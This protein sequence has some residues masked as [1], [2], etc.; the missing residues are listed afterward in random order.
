MLEGCKGSLQYRYGRYKELKQV[1]FLLFFFSLAPL[2]PQGAPEVFSFFFFFPPPWSLLGDQ[3]VFFLFSTSMRS[4]SRFF[5]YSLYNNFHY[6]MYVCLCVCGCGCV[7]YIR[8]YMCKERGYLYV[9]I[10]IHTY[11]Y[12]T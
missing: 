1:F 12:T 5:F 6:E 10:Y 7:S 11:I 8:G 9:Y 2:W 3:A 4:S